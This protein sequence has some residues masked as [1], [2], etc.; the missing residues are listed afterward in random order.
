MDHTTSPRR[1]VRVSLTAALMVFLV[2]GVLFYFVLRRIS[3]PPVEIDQTFGL[4][5]ITGVAESGFYNPE[6]GNNPPIPYRWT[7]GSA[8]LSI[9]FAMPA[10]AALHVE[11][12]DRSD[13]HEPL[14]D[15]RTDFLVARAKHHQIQGWPPTK[16]SR[17]QGDVASRLSIDPGN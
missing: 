15:D 14:S 4:E 12:A 5:K 6:V 10:P 7:N 3:P 2:V 13:R 8:R 9:P 11:V 17:A 1:K 16:D